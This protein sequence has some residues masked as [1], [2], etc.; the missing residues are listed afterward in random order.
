MHW[1][2]FS[3]EEVIIL[4]QQERAK[5]AE[6][7]L[8]QILGERF[9]SDPQDQTFYDDHILSV[10]TSPALKA[11]DKVQEPGH[12]VESYLRVK[13]AQRERFSEF[14]QRLTRIVQIGITDPEPRLIIIE[15]LAYE[16][17]NI[18]CKRILDPLN[19]RSAPMNE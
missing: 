4:E 14:L 15:S 19:I 17:A 18:E 11:W 1:R 8:R 12:N 5:G 3:K 13:Q 16:Y 2:C 6:N 10:C 7:S 9:Y